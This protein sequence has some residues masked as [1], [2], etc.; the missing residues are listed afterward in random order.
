MPYQ[1]PAYLK[2]QRESAASNWKRTGGPE[3]RARRISDSVLGG[4]IGQEGAQDYERQ[5]ALRKQYLDSIKGQVATIGEAPEAIRQSTLA[6]LRDMRMG[7]SQA[8]AASLGGAGGA[9]SGGALASQMRQTALERGAMSQQYQAQQGEAQQAAR[10]RAAQALSEGTVAQKEAGSAFGDTQAKMDEA[11]AAIQAI[12]AANSGEG[13]AFGAGPKANA[14]QK[15]IME[16]Q[17]RYAGDPLMMEW[18]ERQADLAYHK[19]V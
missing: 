14:T 6:G 9:A 13:G 7:T 2:E 19:M 18:I 16:L 3:S 11:Q 5:Q 8:L 15:E 10:E 1:E 4:R 12:I 17:A